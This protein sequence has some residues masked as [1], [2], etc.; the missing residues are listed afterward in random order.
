MSE[1]PGGDP[2]DD[3]LQRLLRTGR[4][5]PTAQ[6]LA[7]D[8]IDRVRSFLSGAAATD[9]GRPGTTQTPEPPAP[10]VPE[11]VAAT[12]A[13]PAGRAFLTHVVPLAD[14][15]SAELRVPARLTRA[16]A[17][18]LAGVLAALAVDEA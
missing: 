10:T 16:E 7:S 15:T 11:P 2:I 6:R 8:G 12:A 5:D 14:G 1:R 9:P 3:V 18:R 17:D 4:F 13:E